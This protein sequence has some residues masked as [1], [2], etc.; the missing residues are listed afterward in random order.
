[1]QS[2]D[3][4]LDAA[5]TGL[6]LMCLIHCLLLPVAGAVLP[7]AGALAEMEWIHKALVLSAFPI[8]AL[9][10]M[11]HGKAMTALS[12]MVPAGAGLS[13]LFA[14]GFIEALEAVETPVTVIGA[15]LLAG[16]HIWRWFNR[17]AIQ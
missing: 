6:S 8:T 10:M 15:S 12:F 11:R 7:L 17:R 9:A 5:A 13:L 14:A 1:M 3:T 4:T 2:T 16:A